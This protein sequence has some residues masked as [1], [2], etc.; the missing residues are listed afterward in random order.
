MEDER[1]LTARMMVSFS[2]DKGGREVDRG[3]E[4]VLNVAEFVRLRWTCHLWSH[5]NS[6]EHS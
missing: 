6:E 4:L 5:W 3:R 2:R 1:G